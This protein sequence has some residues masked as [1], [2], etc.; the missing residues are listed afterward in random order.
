MIKINSCERDASARDERFFFVF[1]KFTL[2]FRAC[3]SARH[4]RNHN[5]PT[6]YIAKYNVVVFSL[7]FYCFFSFSHFFRFVW[8][9]LSI[10]LQLHFFFLWLSLLFSHFSFLCK[11][12]YFNAE[13]IEAN[14]SRMVALG[15]R[16]NCGG[17]KPIFNN[18][19]SWKQH[20]PK[21]TSISS[22]FN[23]ISFKLRRNFLINF[24]IIHFILREW[25]RGS[26]KSTSKLIWIHEQRKTMR[27]NYYL[28]QT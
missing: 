2:L 14:P 28:K 4:K 10:L 12:I 7:L 8:Y 21:P 6:L 17:Q 22:I 9:K 5:Q 23:T 16:C 15:R 3:P 26:G 11:P 24:P 19:F 18:F 25:K 27:L 20:T 13:T 1:A